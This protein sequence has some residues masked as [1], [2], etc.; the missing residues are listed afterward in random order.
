MWFPGFQ[1][2]FQGT[3]ILCN[4]LLVVRILDEGGGVNHRYGGAK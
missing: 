3:I 4:L 1:V 2:R